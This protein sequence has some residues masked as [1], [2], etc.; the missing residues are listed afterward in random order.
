MKSLNLGLLPLLM[1]FATFFLFQNDANAT[2]VAGGYI[3]FKCTGTPG[4]YRVR[5]ILYRDCSGIA[6]PT[7]SIN[8]ELTNTCGFGKQSPKLAYKSKR[9]VSQICDAELKNTKCKKKSNSQPGYEEFIY[10]AIVSINDCDSW[11]AS[12]VLPDRN[13]TNNLV[14][15]T[16]F[17]AV[18]TVNTFTDNCNDT[19]VVSA[20]PEPFVCKDQEVTYNLGASEPDGDSISY[21]L[22]P[23][24]TSPGNNVTY[25]GGFDGANPIPGVTIDPVSGTVNFTPTV[26]GPYVFVVEMTEY[27]SN[28][29][30][31]TVT[32]YEYQTYVDN[33]N[34]I[35]PR[36]PSYNPGGGITNVTGSVVQNSP[37]SLTLCQGFEGCFDVV[38]TDPD[39]DDVLDIETNINAVMPG[40]TILEIGGNPLTA[41]ICWTP[42][43][44]SGTV[45]LNF[46][47]EDDACPITGQNNYAVTINVVNPGVSSVTTTNETCGGTNLGTARITVTGG[48]PPFVYN[49]NGPKTDSESTSA[50]F[51]DFDNLPPGDYTYTVAT[52]GGCDLTGTFT[53]VEGPPLP[54][55][56]SKTDLTCNAKNDG[57]ATATPTA[58]VAPYVYV[59]SQGGTPIGQT[60]QTADNLSAETYSVSVTDKL[61]CVTEE[62][63]TITQP[64]PLAGTLT[65]TDALCHGEATGKIDV[66][67]VSGG[68]S[69]YNYTLDGGTPQT[70]TGFTG[71]V[72][73]DHQVII[74]DAKDCPLPLTVV[75]GQ[76]TKLT[77]AL[78]EV[79]NATCGSNS[80]AIDVTASGGSVPYQYSSG[81]PNQGSGSFTNM[82]PGSYNITVTDFYGCTAVVPATVGAVA[83]PTAFV[84][85][86]IDLSCFGGNNGQVVIGTSGALAPISYSLNGGTGQPSNTFT[87][88]S[89]GAYTVVITDDNSCTA[90][91]S[92]TIVQ[93]PV[94]TYTSVP[95][96]ASCAGNCD[97]EITIS[98]SGGTTPYEYS[99]NNGLSFST[100]PTLGGLC[101]GPIDVVVRDYNGCLANSNVVISEPDGLTATYVNTDPTCKDGDDGEIVVTVSGGTPSYEFG[102][103]GS[104]LQSGNTL[105]GLTAGNHDVYIKDA[106]GC[107]L[108]SIQV[109]NNPPG[110]DIDT[111]SMTPSNCGF[112]DGAIEFIAS[113]ANPPFLYSMAG[114]P[115]QSSG[116]F[117]NQLAG[118]YKVIVTDALGCQDS[119]FFGINDV[120]MDGDLVRT[121]DVSCFGG[122]DGEVEVVSYLGVPVIVFELDNSGTTQTSPTF[123]GIP[124]GSHIV[125]IYD[126]GLCVFTIPFNLTQPDEIDFSAN[127]TDATCNG[128][129]SGEIEVINLTGGTGAYQLS[130]DGGFTF[131]ASTTFSNLAAG[132]YTITVLDDNFCFVSKTFTVDEAPIITFTTNLFNLTCNNNNTGLIQ[133][134]ASGG[135]GTYTY[136]ADNGASFQASN[137]FAGLPAGNYDL[138][139]RDAAGCEVGGN[140]TLTEPAPLT[141]TYTPL[142]A[143]CFGVCDGEIAINAVGGTSP[144]LYSIDNGITMTSSNNITGICASTFDVLVRDDLG[145]SIVSSQTVNEP[146]QVTFT[147]VEDP[148]TC[149]NPNGEITITANGGTPNYNYSIDNG[150]SFVTGN[151]FNG[152]AEG[153]YYIVVQDDNDCPASGVQEVTNQASPVITM[154]EKTDP[155]C[156]G[157]ANGEI[158]V[159]ATG[160]T[161]TLTYSVNGGAPQASNILANIP[162]GNHT[163]TITDVNGCT[164]IK[165]IVL[166]HPDPLTFTSEPT[167]L[168]C[169]QN[170]TGKILVVPNGGTPGYQYS[171]DNGATFSSSPLNNFIAAGTYDIVLK[172]ANGCE[173]SG[174]EIV[175]EP[176]ELVFDNI[177]SS[178]ALCMGS[179]DGEIQLTVSGGVAPYSYNWVQSVAGPNDSQATGLCQG[180]YDFIVEDDNG[181]LIND[182][183]VINQPDSVEI[184]DVVLTNITC[185]GDC[186]GQIEINSPTASEFSID[187]GATFQAS[188]LFE[189]LCANDYD[190]V[191]KDPSGC[192]VETSVNIWEADPLELSISADT[193][194]CHAYN[195]TI[196]GFPKGG[197]QPYTYQW[198]NGG[199]TLDTL[200]I[201][202]TDTETY[203]LDLF[204]DNGCTV[205]TESV[206]ITVIPLVDI[207]VLQDTTICHGGSATISAQGVDGLA[208]YD[209]V[210]DNGETSS[211]IIVSPTD[212]T[213]Y[214]AT[215]T[216]QCGDQATASATVDFYPSPDVT[217]EGDNLTGCIPHTVNFT[218][219]TNPSDVGTNCIWTINGQ[220]FTGCSDIEYTFNAA[221]CYDVTLQVESPFGCVS[222]TKLADYVCVDDYPIADFSYNP[223]FPTS[224]NNVVDFT[225]TSIGGATYNWTFEGE[226][227]TNVVN[228]KVTF[229]K[230]KEATEITVCLEVTSKYGC[231]DEVCKDIEFKEEFAVYVPNTFTPDEDQHNPIFKPVFPPGSEIENYQLQI[232]NRWGEILF[233]SFDYNIGWNGTYG[234]GSTD[235]V[236]DGVYVWKIKVTEG[237]ERK[238]REFVGHVTLLK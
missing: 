143:E 139:V 169:Y 129:A 89:A 82:A 31:V 128:A 36:P 91:V 55:T 52:G 26:V 194:V 154:L 20:Q 167:T 30:I 19:P 134:V 123:N 161:G 185:H 50:Q 164:D 77:V 174:T 107:E 56:V 45:T 49:I 88:L 150:A 156:N 11:T 142:D 74:K 176:T 163:V 232:F 135:T 68:T 126:A 215:V 53:I 168:L 65:P 178:D 186:D 179:C 172:D 117:V 104:V 204:D 15:Q 48:V 100:N 115:N 29:D 102:V 119:V 216:D 62:I 238:Q 138:V 90:S 195:H 87:G 192:I 97:G 125:T 24:T 235:I 103:N 173:V 227:T 118:A 149:S 66:S 153:T 175:D 210:W 54:V 224:V 166:T 144:Y 177:T 122:S 157:D 12:Y 121:T 233:E 13:T 34:N 80:G 170:S 211:S 44:T 105:T 207:V 212:I 2:H 236:K 71:V 110:I 158:V 43:T 58:G 93:P 159:T 145:C 200:A 206:T 217:F 146:T 188:N 201:V 106:N 214:T 222:S 202:A 78:D 190:I 124:E 5:L 81:G 17:N 230:I 9:E 83:V 46:I 84:D 165:D 116:L 32:R 189:N 27:N 181:C 197:I 39:A 133:I 229:G 127:I 196:E 47:V 140:V 162:D 209:Y 226:G 108:E 228:P 28:G 16:P 131:Q 23:A 223:Q 22:V 60:T 6:L 41:S 64:D 38:F 112:N 180:T 94:L 95:T 141:A 171:F 113:G 137:T 21:A 111:L 182:L 130:I 92:F 237:S 219:T 79:I 218:N 191:A 76:P 203:T 160:G 35:P 109:L 33:C 4:K 187:G 10:E 37:S 69:P 3:E 85:N 1:F 86:Q 114:S 183:V 231:M 61:G 193:T 151:N 220:T 132:T 198:S 152:L 184:S 73:G 213:T 101:A 155:L 96:P 51:S 14:G 7:S 57:T 225:N 148:S 75:V 8:I 63:V 199:S 98:A 70:G 234:V 67:G 42:V 99:S 208:G 72:A 136:S 18:T 205:P 120:Q 147:S 59:W 40:A 25:Q 221:F